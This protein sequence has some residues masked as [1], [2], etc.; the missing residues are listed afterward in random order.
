MICSFVVAGVCSSGGNGRRELAWYRGV[1][2]PERGIGGRVHRDGVRHHQRVR[3]SHPPRNLPL[4]PR[5]R[6]RRGHRLAGRRAS[7]ASTP[8]S[9]GTTSTGWPRAATSKSHGGPPGA[10][11]GGPPS[12]TALVRC[13]RRRAGSQRRSRAVAAGQALAMLPPDG[14]AQMA[15]EV[16]RSTAGRWP[17]ADQRPPGRRASVPAVGDAG[18]GRRMTA[19]GSRPTPRGGT[20]TLRSERHCPFGDVA[21]EHPVICAVDRGMVEGIWS[22]S[23]AR[24]ARRSSPEWSPS[25]A[26]R[27]ATRSARPLSRG[28][29]RRHA[30]DGAAGDPDRAVVVDATRGPARRGR[31]PFP[32]WRRTAR[33]AAR[34]EQPLGERGV[35]AAGD[36][37]LDRGA[38]LGEERPDLD[39]RGRP[40]G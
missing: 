32:G 17:R 34:S 22:T 31:A 23:T 19:H 26:W 38:V 13:D 9:P 1:V 27:S 15:E 14:A 30:G 3:G 5:T 39:G 10:V 6:R 21:I 29:P 8:T 12:A 25:R 24:T 11:P 2:E 28:R 4:R 37:V 7:S 36:R 33:S 40:G 20:T 18:G 35:E 16:A